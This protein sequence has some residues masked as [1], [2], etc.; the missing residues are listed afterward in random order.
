MRQWTRQQDSKNLT[1]LQGALGDLSTVR[2]DRNL[3]GFEVAR[4]GVP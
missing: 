4:L 1:S 2:L 3:E